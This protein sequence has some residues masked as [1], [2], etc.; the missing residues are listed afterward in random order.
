MEQSTDYEKANLNVKEF[1]SISWEK[2]NFFI[3]T[4]PTKD[5]KHSSYSHF[6]TYHELNSQKMILY[7]INKE[8]TTIGWAPART[9]GSRRELNSRRDFDKKIKK[10]ALGLYYPLVQLVELTPWLRFTSLLWLWPY[11]EITSW[12]EFTT[13]LWQKNKKDSPWSVLSSRAIGRTHAVT[14]IHVVTLALAVGNGNG[15]QRP[16]KNWSN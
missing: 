14:S 10:I 4:D 15:G 12:N 11:I 16:W 7:S 2:L 8:R 9:L 6:Y 3:Q 5:Y 13:W 1:P